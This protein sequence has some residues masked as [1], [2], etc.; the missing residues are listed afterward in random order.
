M[1][2]LCVWFLN[3]NPRLTDCSP[4]GS[5]PPGR[6]A[7]SVTLGVMSE[8]EILDPEPKPG[9]VSVAPGDT[10]HAVLHLGPG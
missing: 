6:L 9:A 3:W 4:K 1:P 10:N 5:L 8:V 7:S 2:V